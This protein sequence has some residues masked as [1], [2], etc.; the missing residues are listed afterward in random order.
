[1]DWYS[2]VKFLH[3]TAAIVW[4]G[5]GFMLI[6]MGIRAQRSGDPQQLMY[7]LRNTAALGVVLFMPA[8]MLTLV[9]GLVLSLLWTGFSDLWIIIGLVGAG[10]TFLTGALFI[11]PVGDRI[12]AM[13]EKDGV[14]PAV[15]MEGAKL[16]RIAKFDYTVMIVVIAD[17]VLKPGESDPAILAAMAAV[18][19]VG[20]LA[21]LVPWR[22]APPV[23]A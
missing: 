16:L 15:Q 6:I 21:F 2:I 11:K 8:S 17:M 3:I 9:F 5:G 7:H 12:A 20:A 13:M 4:L 14:T 1:M 19:V 18:T 10:M 22:P 23:A